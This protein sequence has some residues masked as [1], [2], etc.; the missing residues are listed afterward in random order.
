M[1]ARAATGVGIWWVEAGAATN[2]GGG[3]VTAGGPKAA[4]VGRFGA[5]AASGDGAWDHSC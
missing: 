3:D 5:I 1:L 4:E 2:A